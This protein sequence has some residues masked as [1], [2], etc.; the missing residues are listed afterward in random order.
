M[1][2]QVIALVRTIVP[3]LVG[4]FS[5]F[6]LTAGIELDEETKTAMV[7]ALTGLFAG[8][9]YALIRYIATKLPLAG[10]LLGHPAVP[11]YEMPKELV[12]KAPV[13]ATKAKTAAK[14]K[15][16]AKK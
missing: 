15:S 9:Y 3:T 6:L 12:K 14:A 4:A 2:D 11:V 5:A 1:N 8:G 13:S 16:G 10:W 7:V